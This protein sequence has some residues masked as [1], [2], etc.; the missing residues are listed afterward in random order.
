MSSSCYG[1]RLV[2]LV[3][4]SAVGIPIGFPNTNSISV[5]RLV[6]LEAGVSV[7][8][9]A[10]AIVPPPPAGFVAP[11]IEVGP[12][13]R[14]IK[15]TLGRHPRPEGLEI[16]RVFPGTSAEAAGLREGDLITAVDGIPVHEREC[17]KP[18][19]EPAGQRQVLTY[20]RE[21]VQAQVEIR[22]E[23]LIP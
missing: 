1:V 15:E 6:R 14:V 11:H 16:I 2:A 7:P 9:D 19:G 17:G 5:E 3:V 21:G 8:S 10:L 12:V 13:R 23:I 20:L 18:E 22:T 4:N